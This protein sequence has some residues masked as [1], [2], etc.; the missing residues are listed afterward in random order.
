PWPQLGELRRRTEAAGHE[1]RERLA[2]YPE[3]AGCAAFV[4]ERLRPRVSAFIAGDG[5]VRPELEQWRA[6]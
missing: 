4:D 1:L 6:W 3:Y 5:L 2:I